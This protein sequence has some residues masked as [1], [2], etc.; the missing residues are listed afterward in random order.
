MVKVLW[1]D[2]WGSSGWA[3]QSAIVKEHAP[4]PVESYGMVVKHDKVG[5]SIASGKD[6]NGAFLG[7]G[8]VPKGMIKEVIEL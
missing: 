5:I 2:A 7:N 6:A 4:L 1:G 3:S 8:F